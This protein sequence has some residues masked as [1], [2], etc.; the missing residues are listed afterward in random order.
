MENTD[1]DYRGNYILDEDYDNADERHNRN[2]YTNVLPGLTL[3]YDLNDRTVLRA[4]FTTALAVR[5]TMRWCPMWISSAR[6]A[7]LRPAIRT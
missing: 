6:N 2:N 4:A 7:K 5:T 1:L 3:K